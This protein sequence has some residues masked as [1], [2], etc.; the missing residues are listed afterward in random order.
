[1]ISRFF[2]CRII[3]WSKVTPG[4]TSS[5]DLSLLIVSF[6]LI[7]SGCEPQLLFG[8]RLFGMKTAIPEKPALRQAP[9]VATKT[10]TKFSFQPS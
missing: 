9:S 8:I 7:Q 2:L 1:M 4:K 10:R 3:E 6:G 5:T